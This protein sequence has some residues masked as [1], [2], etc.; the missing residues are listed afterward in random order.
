MSRRAACGERGSVLMLMPA[1]VLVVLL[2][3]AVAVDSA[4]VHLR[5]RQAYN[6]AFDAAN[7]AAGAG[8][9]LHV[10]R[11]TGRFVHDPERVRAIA[12]QAIDASGL[13][14]L[15][16]IDAGVDGEDVVVTVE[17]TVHHLFVQ[18]FG[19]ASSDTL[20]VTARAV[21]ETRAP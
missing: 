20:R 2:L 7:D 21:A 6:V 1:A 10:A 15:V 12:E 9:D 5:Q 11:V 4:V 18:A 13:D 16:L 8:I 3:G 19:D 14:E 17:I